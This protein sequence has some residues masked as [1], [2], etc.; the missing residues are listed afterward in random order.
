MGATVLIG[1]N[2]TKNEFF[3]LDDAQHINSFALETSLGRLSMWSLNRDKQCGE[4]YTNTNTIKTFCSGAKQTDGEY[5]T[6]L[7][8]GLT[9]TPGSIVDFDISK[10]DSS[11]SSTQSYPTW[12]AGTQYRRGDKVIWNGN[13]Y[14]ALGPSE[15]EQPDSAENG[16]DAQWRIIGPVL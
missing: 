9:G 12:S 10:M 7:G 5:A 8:S 15:N 1:Q 13:I 11:K 3:T 4:N 14:E 6:M 2:D 16:V